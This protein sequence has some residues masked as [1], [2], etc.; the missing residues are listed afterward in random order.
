MVSARLLA[1]FAMFCLV[2]C[3]VGVVDK[4]STSSSITVDD[5]NGSGTPPAP[6]AQCQVL[7]V[8]GGDNECFAEATVN[9][10]A[11]ALCTAQKLELR[12]VARS[13][14]CPGGFFGIKAT[15]CPAP[16]PPQGPRCEMVDIDLKQ[17][18]KSN[19]VEKAAECA[20]RD[21]K[22]RVKSIQVTQACNK[23]ASKIKVECCEKKKDCDDK[24]DDKHD[25]DKHDGKH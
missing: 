21:R 22:L 19:E 14:P 24:H 13:Q 16:Q 6:D 17:C 7:E 3:G 20:C 18:A 15:C 1:A 23:G 2:A 25:D 12:S 11:Q 10:R 8:V 4:T 5:G 9:S